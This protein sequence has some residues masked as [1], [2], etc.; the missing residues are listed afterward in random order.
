MRYIYLI[1]LLIFILMAP[2]RNSSAQISWTG[3]EMNFAPDLWYNDVDGIRV[4]VRMRGQVPGTF[5]DGP[6]RLDTGVWFG[7][8]YPPN[9]F[10]YYIKY[11]NPIESISD[12]NSEGSYSIITSI[13]TGYH[14]HGLRFDK[15]WQPGFNEDVYREMFV[16]TGLHRHYAPD[17]LPFPVFWQE[18]WTA[19]LHSGFQGQ[20]LNNLGYLFYKSTV[21]AGYV[22]D[23]DPF[24]VLQA[25]LRQNIE[26]NRSFNVR[27]RASGG[28]QS[29]NTTPEY[30]LMA[31]LA[32]AIEWMDSGFYRAKGTVPMPWMNSGVFQ[33]TG[34]GPNLR[35]YA[36]RDIKAAKNTA[37]NFPVQFSYSHYLAFNTELDFPNPVDMMFSRIPV[38]GDFLRLRSYMFMD[39]LNGELESGNNETIADAG[40]GFALTLNIPD[41]IGK[42]RGF[43]IRYDVPFWLSGPQPGHDPIR[44]RSVFS[45]GAVIGF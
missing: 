41:Q 12:F 14:R 5:D 43:V 17:Y 38:L 15:R 21:R 35:G 24:A 11:T 42:P 6:H 8:W 7:V 39:V 32:P 28:V 22:Q 19:F 36:D 13:R 30:R 26:L 10:S 37:G 18:D 2:A 29:E 25:E 40:A 16:F 27:L 1:I 31:S 20:T 45:F 9:P 4:G 34:S 44:Y 23:G 3:Y 33:V